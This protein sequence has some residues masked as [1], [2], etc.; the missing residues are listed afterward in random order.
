MHCAD[1]KTAIVVGGMSQEKQRKMLKRSPEIIIAT[2]GRLWDL[3]KEKHPHLQNLRQVRS[4]LV[5]FVSINF[6]VSHHTSYCDCNDVV[7]L[8]MPGY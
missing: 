1:I 6:R 4:V 7:I 5:L 3:I 2:P 8:Q